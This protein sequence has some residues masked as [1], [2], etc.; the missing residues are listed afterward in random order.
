MKATGPK[1]V[2]I[3]KH[4]IKNP[5]LLRRG[6][7]DN[8]PCLLCASLR[9]HGHTKQS[10][11]LLHDKIWRNLAPLAHLQKEYTPLH[12]GSEGCNPFTTKMTP[13]QRDC[14]LNLL[15]GTVFLSIHSYI[16][17]ALSPSPVCQEL[18]ERRP[19]QA[20]SIAAQMLIDCNISLGE[21]FTQAP[22]ISRAT[23]VYGIAKD[24]AFVFCFFP[25]GFHN[26]SG[27]IVLFQAP[28]YRMEAY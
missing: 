21:T 11:S 12:Q 27:T 18:C 1:A 6:N 7:S 14:F 17:G 24:G 10:V 15:R 23:L 20:A 25:S 5:L 4:Q 3:I 9:A 16:N 22:E 2:I 26:S 8:L 28:V 13:E 19:Q